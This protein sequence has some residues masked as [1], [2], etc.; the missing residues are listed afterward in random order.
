MLKSL[1]ILL[2]ASLIILGCGGAKQTTRS[3]EPPIK[4]PQ[5]TEALV[6]EDFD[7]LSLKEPEFQIPPQKRAV[8]TE[9]PLL[10]N[11]SIA[12]TSLVQTAGYQLQVFQTEDAGLARSVARESAS[13]LGIPTEIIFDSPYFKI[14]A[15]NFVNRFDAEQ[16]QELAASKGYAGA[17]VVRTNVK[18]RA[19]ELE[20]Q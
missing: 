12:D 16:L 9:A 3:S 2:C 5:T 13:S 6:N 7:P 18:V 8:E 17:W 11:T 4:K 15:G 10:Q 19:N 14:R 1:A 20:R